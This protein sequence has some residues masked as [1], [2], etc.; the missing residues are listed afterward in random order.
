M[1]SAG[2]VDGVKRKADGG[3]AAVSTTDTAGFVKTD[4]P[5]KK[6]GIDPPVEEGAAVVRSVS[7]IAGPG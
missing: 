2:M 7:A 6:L 4:E 1:G 3:G 5:V